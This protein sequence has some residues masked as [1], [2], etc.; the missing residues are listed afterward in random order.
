[1]RKIAPGSE[2]P[3]IYGAF[4]TFTGVMTLLFQNKSVKTGQVA[5]SHFRWLAPQEKIR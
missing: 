3:Q 1:M 2:P 4:L 5:E